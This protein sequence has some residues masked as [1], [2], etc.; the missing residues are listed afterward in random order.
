L[1]FLQQLARVAVLRRLAAFGPIAGGGEVKILALDSGGI[2][3]PSV[4]RPGFC[5]IVR[6]P[7]GPHLVTV[8][9][10]GD[11]ARQVVCLDGLI[12]IGVE[13][14]AV[15]AGVQEH[16]TLSA[17]GF[18]ENQHRS[19]HARIGLEHAAWKG[20]HS[21]DP[22][23]AC[24]EALKERTREFDPLDRA[25]TQD[26]LGIALFRLGERKSGTARLE[27]A[28]AAY[29]E[30]LKER[31]RDRVPLGW[32][33]TQDSLGNALRNFGE[34]ESGTARLEEAVAACRAALEECTRERVPFFWAAMQDSLGNALR[35][36]GERESGTAR[37]EEAVAACREALK[38]WTREAAP[39]WH[40]IAR[41]NL[42]RCVALLKQR[43]EE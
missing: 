4:F 16:Y 24:R 15:I 28:V 36:L 22:V 5:R 26:S 20:K 29:R 23:A 10:G 7:V 13:L 9:E 21:L 25:A 34:R 31:T 1:Q 32:A 2:R 30:A 8:V 43:R 18:G 35:A 38:E 14:E 6:L 40:D 42:A 37:L 3:E 27:E 19:L 39:Y 11:Q 12:V 41:Q 33:A 17:V